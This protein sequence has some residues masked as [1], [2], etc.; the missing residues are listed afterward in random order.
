M[1]TSEQATECE[2]PGTYLALN[3]IFSYK[4][5]TTRK[6]NRETT[7]REWVERQLNTWAKL[8][9]FVQKTTCLSVSLSPHNSTVTII[10]K[11]FNNDMS[12]PITYPIG[13]ITYKADQGSADYTPERMHWS[14]R[15][16]MCLCKIPAVSSARLPFASKMTISMQQGKLHL[17]ILK[18]RSC[19][20][21]HY[22]VELKHPSL[23]MIAAYRRL[24]PVTQQW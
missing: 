1:G 23:S 21:H 13:L 20:S 19:N 6:C 4:H 2:T 17:Q 18:Q 10:G 22:D 7:D 14:H 11:S 15:N 3:Q 8:M 16:L 12:C 9:L 5:L 24:C